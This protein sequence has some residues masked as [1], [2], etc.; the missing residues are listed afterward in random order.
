MC[1]SYYFTPL[2]HIIMT[3]GC[4]SAGAGLTIKNSTALY[5]PKKSD[6]ITQDNTDNL[7]L[8]NFM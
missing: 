7:I 1:R 6:P 3:V 4:L 2:V 5:F 8:R